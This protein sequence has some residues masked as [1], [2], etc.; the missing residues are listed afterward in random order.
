[1]TEPKKSFIRRSGSFLLGYLTPW[2]SISR[3]ASSVSK[4]MS[5]IA[6]AARAARESMKQE[7]ERIQAA[8][9]VQL[10][11]EERRMSPAQL[12]DHYF[13]IHGWTEDGLRNNRIAFRRA[14]WACLA[15]GFASL[16]SGLIMLTVSHPILAFVIA[17]LLL[18]CSLI[19]CS[20]GALEAWK[21]A[22]V[23]LRQ[24]FNFK[25]FAGRADFFK[26]LVW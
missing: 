20:R 17:P 12:F 16:V 24:V 9:Q 10:T 19:I 8:K 22:Q 23:E 2:R 11:P 5:N 7:H 6:D 21:E 3:S 18:I 14:K 13:E 1:M 26:R 4:S 15:M 25:H